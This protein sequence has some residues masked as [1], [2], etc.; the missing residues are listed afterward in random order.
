MSHKK[1]QKKCFNSNARVSSK[2]S[3]RINKLNVGLKR[4]LRPSHRSS[5]E[6]KQEHFDDLR[7][8]FGIS[9]S[10][11]LFIHTDIYFSFVLIFDLLYVENKI[12]LGQIID[13]WSLKSIFLAFS[14][15]SYWME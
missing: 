14:R 12:G 2:D 4:G 11:E 10:I 13:H 5:F 6:R 9:P 8:I 15:I 3:V 7:F 1:L